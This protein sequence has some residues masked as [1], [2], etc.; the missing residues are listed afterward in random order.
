MPPLGP[1]SVPPLGRRFMFHRFSRKTMQRFS[2]FLA[3]ELVGPVKA[4]QRRSDLYNLYCDG[5]CSLNAL[6]GH[7]VHKLYFVNIHREL[8]C[9]ACWMHLRVCA[10]TFA[11]VRSFRLFRPRSLLIAAEHFDYINFYFPTLSRSK[12]SAQNCYRF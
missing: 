3:Y 9:H 6:A 10:T 12:V 4:N 11:K 7:H 8:L 5:L 1:I 2:L